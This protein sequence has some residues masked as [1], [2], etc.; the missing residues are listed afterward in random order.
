MATSTIEIKGPEK[1]FEEELHIGII[2][3]THPQSAFEKLYL[4]LG[5]TYYLLENIF[6][7]VEKRGETTDQIRQL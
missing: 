7:E 3:K 4:E 2:S 1:M 5:G 6:G